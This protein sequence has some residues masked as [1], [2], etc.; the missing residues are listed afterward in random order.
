MSNYLAG[1]YSKRVTPQSESI[2][3]E[4]QIQNAAGGFVY[5]LD[6]WKRLERFLVLGAEGGTY[7]VG[8]RKLVRENAKNVEDCIAE[9]GKR[10]IEMIARVSDEGRAP[11][12]DPAIF[13]LA[14]GASADDPVTRALALGALPKVCRIPPHLFHFVTYVKQFRGF[15]RGLKR[16]LGDWYNEMPVERLAYLVVKYQSRS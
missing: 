4:V 15:G 1:A 2:P 3:G 16:A 9:D 13:A 10:A 8:E 12:N 14:L 6:K 5:N 7:Y 11:K